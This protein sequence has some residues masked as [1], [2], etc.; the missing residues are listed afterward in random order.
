MQLLSLHNQFE[1]KNGGVGFLVD[2]GLFV[3]LQKQVQKIVLYIFI[4][5]S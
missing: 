3:F 1:V 4:L 2:V 5:L